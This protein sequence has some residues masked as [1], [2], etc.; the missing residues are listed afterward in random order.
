MEKAQEA[1]YMEC[2]D[3]VILEV[4]ADCGT[5][6]GIFELKNTGGR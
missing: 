5:I 6:A 3:D 4:T 2:E 1:P